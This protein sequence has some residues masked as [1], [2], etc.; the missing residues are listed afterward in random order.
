MAS[1]SGRSSTAGSSRAKGV[2]RYEG[3]RNEAMD[4]AVNGLPKEM[5]AKRE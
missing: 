3:V 5:E 1:T 4:K 2:I